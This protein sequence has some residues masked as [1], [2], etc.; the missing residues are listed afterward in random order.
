M[1]TL[2]SKTKSHIPKWFLIDA[3]KKT[4]GHLSTE[5]TKLLSGK[6][7]SY[8]TPNIDQGN[9][10]IVIN[11]LKIVLTGKKEEQKLYY[12]NPSHRPGNLKIKELKVLKKT[13]PNRILE[14]AVWGMLSKNILGRQIFK[15]LYIYKN[16]KINFF[17][18]KN[19]KLLKVINI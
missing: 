12:S 4:L 9:Y 17:L 2:F 1:I 6:M 15:R 16:N 19:Y 3:T 5:I 7:T 8:Y 11:S 10:V 13:I 14:K 18:S